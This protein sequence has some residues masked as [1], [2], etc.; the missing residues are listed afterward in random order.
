[1]A[2]CSPEV[3]TGYRSNAREEVL[4]SPEV[5]TGTSEDSN[6]GVKSAALAACLLYD[7]PPEPTVRA[8]ALDPDEPLEVFE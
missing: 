2:L 5:M 1:M 6:L 3:H 8:P 4:G 7:G